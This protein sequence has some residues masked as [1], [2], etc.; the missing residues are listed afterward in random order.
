MSEAKPFILIVDDEIELANMVANRLESAGMKVQVYDKGA[1][2]V[3]FLS[4]N[5]V[6]L[7]ILDIGLPDSSGLEIV[8][9]MR[10]QG[11][12]VPVIFL[13]ASD[14]EI[15]KVSGLNYGA[16]DYMTKPFSVP[17]LIARINAI[18]RRAET[19]NDANI[20]QNAR[21]DETP[22]SFC[23]AEVNPM[24]ME[25]A[26]PDGNTIEIG[27]KEL[28][29]LTYLATNPHS[30]QTRSAVIHAVWGVHAD[31]RSRSLDQY[32]AKIRDLFT[33]H[34][35]DLDRFRTI[36]GVGYLYDPKAS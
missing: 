6:N 18:L 3:Q 1:K 9:D 19:S 28:G 10:G 22:F 25:V 2:V 29:I 35:C 14:S 16:D 36:H 24:R 13:T 20:T 33:K 26:F 34:G 15:D 17:E 31:V 5:H 23:C 30:V 32:V 11:I 27:R 8:Q 7:V 12:N 21:L 4:R